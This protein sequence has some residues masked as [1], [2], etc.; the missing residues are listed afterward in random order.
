MKSKH[1]QNQPKLFP[2]PQTRKSEILRVYYIVRSVSGG[3]ISKIF[4]LKCISHNTRHLNA[5][6][7]TYFNLKCQNELFLNLDTRTFSKDKTNYKAKL[8]FLSGKFTG[9]FKNFRWLRPLGLSNFLYC[10][11]RSWRQIH[12]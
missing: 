7:T 6:P 8:G 10:Q 9:D 1:K 2:Y 12:G 3:D 5:S 4:S 11:I